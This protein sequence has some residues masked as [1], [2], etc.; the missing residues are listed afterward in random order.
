MAK[1]VKC[2]YCGQ[3]FDREYSE[4]VKI[5]NRYAHAS[6][7]E[8]AKKEAAALRKL[9][10]LIQELYKPIEPKWELVCRQIQKYKDEGM[11]YMGM[12]YTLTYFF[13]IQSNDIKKGQ[14]VGIIPYVYERA[15]NYYKNVNNVYAK[16]AEIEQQDTLDVS[17]TENII[18]I[19]HKK[20]TKRLIS[21]DYED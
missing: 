1:K 17:Q 7:H 6:C 11:T 9:T 12:Y 10:D 2:K 13:V 8:R 5:S 16:V 20:P 18:T 21:F 14:G 15:R 4:Y 19:A 3:E